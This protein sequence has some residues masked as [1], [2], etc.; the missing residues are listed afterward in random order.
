MIAI[1]P[2]CNALWRNV[3]LSNDVGRR[4]RRR[5]AAGDVELHLSP[6]VVAELRRRAEDDLT[7]ARTQGL[8]AIER[9]TK[10]VAVEAE[11]LRLE[12]AALFERIA[13][14]VDAQFQELLRLP[15]VVV[16]DWPDLSA[17]VLGERELA[18]RRP[19]IDTADGTIGHR[20][21]LIW[22]GVLAGAESLY[23]TDDM[24]VFVS[25]DRAFR[26][27][28]NRSLHPDLS[29]D[30]DAVS[31]A[32]F[33]LVP[34]LFEALTIVD[35]H[36]EAITRRQANIRNAF[37]DLLEHLRGE[38]WAWLG[39][40]LPPDFENPSVI[41]AE[42]QGGESIHE[43]NPALC[44]FSAR[45]EIEGA[46]LKDVYM[47]EAGTDVQTWEGEI[48]DHYVSVYVERDVVFEVE[49]DLTDAGDV[50]SVEIR[51]VHS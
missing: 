19:F 6:V 36:D 25:K 9:A 33:K 1:Y 27:E 45:V 39:G 46:M 13:A 4:L 30:I 2:D 21:A 15:G 10:G 43:G 42:Y 8:L 28:D 16:D 3:T 20:D 41:S 50:D 51:A 26:T 31:E 24:A 11:T 18:R 12:H 34:T 44:E 32:R 37:G 14:S 17:R 7:S 35:L 22:E 40:E 47:V 5:L 38:P 23:E 49:V 48:N 29:M